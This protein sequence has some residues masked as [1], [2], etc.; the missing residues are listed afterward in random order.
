[1][2]KGAP[3]ETSQTKIST[4]ANLGFDATLLAAADVLRNNMDAAVYKHVIL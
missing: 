3:K 2:A 4:E 1:M